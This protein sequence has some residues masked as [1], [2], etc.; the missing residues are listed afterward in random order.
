MSDNDMINGQFDD[1]IDLMAE[2]EEAR[3]LRRDDHLEASQKKLLALLENYPD[4]PLVLFEV[5]G[6]YD[7]LGEEEMA[8]PYYRRAIAAGLDGSD[9]QEC[10]VCLGSTL[11]IVG[12]NVEAITILE[13]AVDEFPE[14]NSGR[15][16]LAL[17]Q[18]SNGEADLAVG[19]LLSVLLDTTT[20]EDILAY[21]D[22]LDYYK[23]NLDETLDE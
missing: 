12:E 23:D 14:R 18:Y 17:A 15:V 13:Q 21:A 8:I 4:D 11:R 9:L 2:I 22:A 5:G 19:T 7:V 10:L 3:E 1:E 16:F 6:S 20:D